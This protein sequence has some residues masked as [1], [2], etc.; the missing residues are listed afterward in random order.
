MPTIT[1]AT[2]KF[3]KDLKANNNRDWFMANKSRYEAVK[4]EFELFMEPLL[5]QISKFDPGIS[6]L[7]A[8]DCIFRIYRDVRFSKDKSPYKTHIGAYISAG[9]RKSEVHEKAGYY[10]HIEPGASL[11]AGGAYVPG[12]DWLKAIRQ[13]IDYNQ[14]EFLS[15][16][17][18]KNFKEYFGEL[19]GE[20]LVKV[21]KG[22]DATHPLIDLL[23]HKSFLAVHYSPDKTVVSD[24]YLNQA[25][26]VFKNISPLNGFLNRCLD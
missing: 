4:S 10:I 20:K 24:S 25:A 14:K 6:G 8:K 12:T 21:P 3:L 1:K 26:R 16:I 23:K 18:N 7:T 9:G 11:L 5:K 19:D 17:R 2:L 13:E 15:V 22:Y